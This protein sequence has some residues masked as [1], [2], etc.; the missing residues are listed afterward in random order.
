VVEALE[1]LTK[2]HRAIARALAHVTAVARAQ[3][4]R[5]LGE[6]SDRLAALL[7]V[8][9]RHFCPAVLGPETRGALLAVLE[10]H[11]DLRRRLASLRL[12]RAD[13]AA[14]AARWRAFR[15][16]VRRS[17]AYE[18]R[19]LFPLVAARCDPAT[20]ERAGRRLRALLGT[21]PL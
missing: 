20:L 13:T 19:A 3:R 11:L 9:D 4:A 1:L 21:L 12:T 18:E 16:R 8:E 5:R 2:R 17:F 10:R 6:A 14:F 7:S 15:A